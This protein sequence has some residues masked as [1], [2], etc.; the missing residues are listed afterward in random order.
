V[1]DGKPT[2]AHLLESEEMKRVVAE[3][4]PSA[5]IVH[6]AR[7]GMVSNIEAFARNTHARTRTRLVLDLDDLE[8]VVRRRGL[9]A[10]PPQRW[11]RRIF[12]YYD[13]ARLSL[14]QHAAV[15]LFD[16]VFVCSGH[17]LRRLHC[18][19]A[20]V[21]PNG[22]VL[23][24]CPLPAGPD[25]RSILFLATL[26]YPPNI[27]ALFFFVRN[28]FPLVQRAEPWARLLVVGNSPAP[29]VGQLHDPPRITVHANVPDV[30][31]YYR[32][33]CVAVVPLRIGG[34]TRLRVLEAFAVGRPV[35][36][37][38]VGCEGLEVA[39]NEHLLVRDDPQ[40][41]AD[42]C[43]QLLRDGDLRGRLTE[44]ARELIAERYTWDS[45]EHRV[46]A[47]AG[48]LLAGRSSK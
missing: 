48:R 4:A 25:E 15:R 35:V 13:L 6:V 43:I 45:I 29:E 16:S 42:A 7:L 26:R 27:D 17:D 31:P 34:G 10:D 28:I 21:V 23:P 18:P 24:A 5:D 12:E 37:T 8:T 39:D 19:R 14:Y 46:G 22:A 1:A 33:A 2:L 11:Q 20:V 38:S 32:Q 44:R 47:I 36:A 9:A 41:F 40:A 30:E 3:A